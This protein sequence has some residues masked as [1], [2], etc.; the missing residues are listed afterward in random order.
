M[1]WRPAWTPPAVLRVKVVV[2]QSGRVAGISVLD[3][4]DALEPT[5]P[6]SKTF[7]GLDVV[8]R[9]FDG[10]AERHHSSAV[11]Y[12]ECE[13]IDRTMSDVLELLMFDEAGNGATD[14]R[15][16][17]HLQVWHFVNADDPDATLGQ[18]FS[19]GIAPQDRAGSGQELLIE[20]GGFPVTGAVRLQVDLFKNAA[21]LPITDGWDDAVEYRLPGQVDAGPVCDVQAFGNGFQTS[22]LDDL[23]SLEGGKAAG[24]CLGEAGPSAVDRCRNAHTGGRVARPWMDR[25]A[26]CKRPSVWVRRWRQPKPHGRAAPERRADTG[27]EK[28]IEASGNRP[29]RDSA[30]KVFGRA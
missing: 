17:Q 15:A 20:P 4:N 18:E 19:M 7:Q 27:C 12:Q 11:N 2:S 24:V 21:D 10:P 23:G 22:Q 5:M 28:R 29:A 30:D 6:S 14:R 8:S 9:V 26:D 16:F 1:D 13:D 3:Q 25:N